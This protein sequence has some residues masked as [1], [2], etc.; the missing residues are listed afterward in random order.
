MIGT[1][2]GLS[3]EASNIKPTRG[4]NASEGPLLWVKSRAEAILHCLLCFVL[5]TMMADVIGSRVSV[6]VRDI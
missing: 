6:S 1:L 4:Q 5:V 2:V 3:V